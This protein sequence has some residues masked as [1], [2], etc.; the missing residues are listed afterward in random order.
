[1]MFDA[2][3]KRYLSLNDSNW[4]WLVLGV[5]NAVNTGIYLSQESWGRASFSGLL[6]GWAM[7]ELYR[8]D[9]ETKEKNNG[10]S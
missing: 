1:M 9:K 3:K 8:I 10:G 7:Y 5:I 6:M 2:M 4:F